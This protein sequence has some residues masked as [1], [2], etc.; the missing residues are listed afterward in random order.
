MISYAREDLAFVGEL[1]ERLLEREIDAWIDLEGL[2]SGEEFWPRIQEAVEGAELVVVILSPHWPVSVPCRRELEHALSN[3]KRV[4]PVLAGDVASDEV[5]DA[6]ANLNWVL[7]TAAADIPAAAEK[8]ARALEEDPRWVRRITRLLVQAREWE[9]ASRPRSRLLRG[10]E[11]REGQRLLTEAGRHHDPQP[12]A[13]QMEFVVAS[14]RHANR[15]RGFIVSGVLTALVLTATAAVVASIQWKAA[16]AERA[17]AVSRELAARSEL[18]AQRDSVEALE[19]A[20][21]AAETRRTREAEQALRD[22][23]RFSR[24]RHVIE[25]AGLGLRSGSFSP[26][27]DRLLMFGPYALPEI[28]D[29]TSGESLAVLSNHSAPVTAARFVPGGDEIL[30]VSE[31]STAR[32]W[33]ASTGEQ[34][35]LYQRHGT[36][37]QAVLVSP[38]GSLAVTADAAGEIRTWRIEGGDDV[39]VGSHET[40][41]GFLAAAFHPSGTLCAFSRIAGPTFLWEPLQGRVRAELALP[42]PSYGIRGLGFSSDGRFLVTYGDA[43]TIRLWDAETGL[44]VESYDSAGTPLRPNRPFGIPGS[45]TV[46]DYRHGLF[47]HSP[48]VPQLSVRSIDGYNRSL[49]VDSRGVGSASFGTQGR[50][51]VTSDARGAVR[52]WAVDSGLELGG[53]RMPADFLPPDSA[54]SPDGRLVATFGNDGRTV[55]WETERRGEV[56][57]LTPEVFAGGYHPLLIDGSGK[58][59][60]GT[61]LEG[62]RHSLVTWSLADGR[63]RRLAGLDIGRP[64]EHVAAMLL[65]PDTRRLLVVWFHGELRELDPGNGEVRRELDDGPAPL[66]RVHLSPDGSLLLGV[67]ASGRSAVWNLESGR[68]QAYLEAPLAGAFRYQFS[69]DGTRLLGQEG[70]GA[71]V[72]ETGTG[73]VVLRRAEV[74][75]RSADFA[76]DSLYLGG[77]AGLWRYRF[78]VDPAVA[79]GGVTGDFTFVEVLP[80]TGE[81]L[82]VD[83]HDGTVSTLDPTLE[84]TTAMPPAFPRPPRYVAASR[85]GRYL[86]GQ[87]DRGPLTLL[88]LHSGGSIALAAAESSSLVPFFFSRDSRYLIVNGYNGVL[89]VYYTGFEDLLAAAKASRPAVTRSKTMSAPSREPAGTSP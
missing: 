10:A 29:T 25:G 20:I 68:I 35:R 87:G 14:S 70:F 63:E 69:D 30:T 47:V 88:D 31:D 13:L 15:I 80:G 3:N 11:L 61:L 9:A 18:A 22:A 72:W 59:L 62:G 38:D 19:L 50:I 36:G 16:R 27:G 76:G 42:S 85:D 45:V 75:V 51:V 82:A 57:S 53:I 65:T 26:E 79:S 48:L 24:V 4:L 86:A 67:G 1:A 21:E 40:G 83:G 41:H 44:H 6:V 73:T 64:P 89:D 7:A 2:F 66:T 32:I 39:A 56:L 84:T 58:R 23:L 49:G 17:I 28:F 77:P 74:P 43:E 60:F 71:R 37:I 5:P 78:D 55:L 12:T 34:L 46:F 52:S 8:V 33:S 54:I 81:V